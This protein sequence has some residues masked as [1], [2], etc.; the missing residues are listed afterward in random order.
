M[1]S[2]PQLWPALKT[3]QVWQLRGRLATA[4]VTALLVSVP[5]EAEA[6]DPN[7]DLFVFAIIGTPVALGTIVVVPLVGLAID[8]GPES[9]YLRSLIF[10]T[11]AAGIGWGIGVAVTSPTND[12]VSEEVALALTALPLLFGSVATYLTY[13]FSSRPENGTPQASRGLQRAVW[14]VPT[15][16][17][18]SLGV[19][20]RL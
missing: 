1:I 10:T 13:R 16:R 17:G 4:V 19:T 5:Q 3:G 18:V 8:Q 9:L 15:T 14:V 7:C 20:L 6:C 11:L 12:Q 2:L